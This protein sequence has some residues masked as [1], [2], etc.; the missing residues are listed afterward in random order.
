MVRHDDT[1]VI[2]VRACVLAAA[3]ERWRYADEHAA[4]I[5]DYWARRRA[6]NPNFFNGAVYVLSAH[7]L[8]ADGVLSG[9]FL[10]T[11]FRSFLY[12]REAGFPEAGVRDAFGS[13]VVRSADGLILL[14]RQRSGHLNSGRCYPPGG[15]V[16]A[17]DVDTDGTVDIVASVARELGEE[18]GLDVR[19]LTRVAGHLVTMT[20]P[21]LSIAVVW[22]SDLP[23]LALADQVRRHLAQDPESELADVVLVA[24]GET[25][26]DLDI[27]HFARALLAALADSKSNT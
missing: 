6:E 23:G 4:E 11:D 18:T 3:N 7:A 25:R 27:P 1:R 22:Q 16:D 2:A 15:L 10:G 14:G 24:P 17:R 20:G 26:S 8:S 19:D 13:A 9:R 21:L 5:A 12:W